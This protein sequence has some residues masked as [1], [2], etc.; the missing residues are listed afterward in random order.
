M[1]RNMRLK[2]LARH[3]SRNFQ[4]FTNFKPKNGVIDATEV[5]NC[6]KKNDLWWD[7]AIK[8]I[9]EIGKPVKKANK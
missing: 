5:F 1:D 4:D 8:R 9:N 3:S 7:D 6:K 2:E